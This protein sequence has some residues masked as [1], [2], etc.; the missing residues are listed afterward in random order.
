MK[1]YLRKEIEKHKDIDPDKLEPLLAYIGLHV[2]RQ[3]DSKNLEEID[4][5]KIASW[6]TSRFDLGV[7]HKGNKLKVHA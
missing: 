2:L 6:L 5:K 4:L 3:K 7:D 1:F